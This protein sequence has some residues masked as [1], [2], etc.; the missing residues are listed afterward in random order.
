M[1]P[2]KLLEDLKNMVGYALLPK[3]LALYP[4][5]EV[6]TVHN[7]HTYGRAEADSMLCDARRR[8]RAFAKA[9]GPGTSY[10]YRFNYWCVCFPRPCAP[11]GPI[12][13]ARERERERGGGSHQKRRRGVIPGI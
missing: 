4:I 5:D 7:L 1:H 12:K 11:P 2:N 13:P 10:M 6:P 8:S 9:R 3:A